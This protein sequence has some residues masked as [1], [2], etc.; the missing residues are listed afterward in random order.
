MS[1]ERPIVARALGNLDIGNPLV[2]RGENGILLPPVYAMDLF[3]AC[4]HGIQGNRPKVGVEAPT[5]GHPDRS[6]WR[7]T[8]GR[9]HGRASSLGYKCLSQ[10]SV[11]C[12]WS[13]SGMVLPVH[14]VGLRERVSHHRSSSEMVATAACVTQP[15]SFV[16][17]RVSHRVL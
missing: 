2:G 6:P 3:D 4:D 13:R 7:E 15:V 16:S 8:P 11:P 12:L 17:G 10:F 14:L 5:L 1:V 9:E